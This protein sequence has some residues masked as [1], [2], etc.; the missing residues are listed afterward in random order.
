MPPGLTTEAE[1]I[2][3]KTGVENG[4]F[5]MMQSWESFNVAC[6][7]AR[8]TDKIGRAPTMVLIDPSRRGRVFEFVFIV[9]IVVVPSGLR[10]ATIG[11]CRA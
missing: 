4:Q 11:R 3:F 9:F 5:A 8:A 10:G 1:S 7:L 6:A 2:D